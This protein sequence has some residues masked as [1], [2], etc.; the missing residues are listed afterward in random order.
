MIL[1]NIHLK[2]GII[3]FCPGSLSL[4]CPLGTISAAVWGHLCWLTSSERLW[5]R[6][7]AQVFS[8]VLNQLLSTRS[9]RGAVPLIPNFQR[10]GKLNSTRSSPLSYVA[11]NLE[12][13]MSPLLFIAVILIFRLPAVPSSV[14]H[15]ELFKTVLL[16]QPI[17]PGPGSCLLPSRSL[18]CGTP[19]FPLVSRHS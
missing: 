11:G 1:P 3:S 2:Q 19:A 7:L 16:A 8:E 10:N 6:A 14:L 17:R 15:P 13:F 4:F 9:S 12:C 5:V 18:K